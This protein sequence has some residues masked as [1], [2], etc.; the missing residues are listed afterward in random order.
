MSNDLTRS[1]V[2]PMEYFHDFVNTNAIPICLVM[3]TY[4]GLIKTKRDGKF[5]S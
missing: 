1:K 2:Y 3:I 4:L 5:R